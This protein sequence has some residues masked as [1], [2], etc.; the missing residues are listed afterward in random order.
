M[1]VCSY[2]VTKNFGKLIW[3]M[4][5]IFWPSGYGDNKCQIKTFEYIKP[6]LNIWAK[7][8]VFNVLTAVPLASRGF[9][10]VGVLKDRQISRIKDKIN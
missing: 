8:T 1:C 10:L 6:I 9:V 2:I 7:F 3:N 4:K 5:K